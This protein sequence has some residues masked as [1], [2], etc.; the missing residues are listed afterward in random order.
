MASV[1]FDAGCVLRVTQVAQTL[2][3]DTAKHLHK[4]QMA[5]VG[6]MFACPTWAINACGFSSHYFWQQSQRYDEAFFKESSLELGSS[7]HMGVF[8]L[9]SLESPDAKHGFQAISSV[10]IYIDSEASRD[11]ISCTIKDQVSIST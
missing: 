1:V 3:G 5:G 10:T 9:S 6:V 4:T 2:H 7:D 8:K 11:E